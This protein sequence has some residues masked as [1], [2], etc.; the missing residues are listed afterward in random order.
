MYPFRPLDQKIDK[1]LDLPALI[2]G[3]PVQFI[4]QRFHD[5]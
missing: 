5:G 4:F 2:R 3:E 1:V